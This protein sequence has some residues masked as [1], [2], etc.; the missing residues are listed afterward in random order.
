VLL[1]PV[2]SM[3]HHGRVHFP[4]DRL[5]TYLRV[6]VPEQQIDDVLDVIAQTALDEEIEDELALFG[7][8]HELMDD[9][10]RRTP[11]M[12]ATVLVAEVGLTVEQ[13]ATALDLRPAV[14]EK[15]VEEAWAETLLAADPL[16]ELPDPPSRAPAPDAPVEPVEV[17]VEPVEVEPVEVEPVEV[18]PVEVEPAVTPEPRTDAVGAAAGSATDEA[19]ASGGSGGGGAWKVVLSGFVVALIALAIA[20]FSEAGRA[21][22]HAVGLDPLVVYLVVVGFIGGGFALDRA[23]AGPT[24]TGS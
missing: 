19:P 3:Q 13:A 23:G 7:L 14:V 10:E 17:E 16:V 15:A 24:D 5:V 21:R 6:F 20:V 11:A 12:E 2:A 22:L 1:T 4:E 8:A 18:E 9:D